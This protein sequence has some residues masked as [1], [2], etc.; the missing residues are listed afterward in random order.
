MGSLILTIIEAARTIAEMQYNPVIRES[1]S[2]YGISVVNVTKVISR[3]L[4]FCFHCVQFT[5]LFRYGNVGQREK[6]IVDENHPLLLVSDRSLSFGCSRWSSSSGH[7]QFLYMGWRYEMIF[8]SCPSWSLFLFVQPSCSRHWNR[9]TKMLIHPA[10]R[11]SRLPTRRF[12]HQVE[13]RRKRPDAKLIPW[14]CRIL[15]SWTDLWWD[16]WLAIHC[17][18]QWSRQWYQYTGADHPNRRSCE[19]LPVSLLDWIQS[20]LSGGV[21]DHVEKYRQTG[22]RWLYSFRWATYLHD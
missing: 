3:I 7:C 4:R 15:F 14:C 17:A 18:D 22:G 19:R 5:F 1:M 12:P 20:H 10:T 2:N 16:H 6:G 9:Y 21:P 8:I 11:L 13:I